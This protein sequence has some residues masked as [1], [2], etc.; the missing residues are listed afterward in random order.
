MFVP[1][2]SSTG[3]PMMPTCPARA[4]R[5]LKAK[6]A[7]SFWSRGVFCIR[8]ND[9][10]ESSTQTIAVGV[11]PGSKREGYTVK[12]KNH[13]F[14]NV[15]SDARTGVKESIETR[16]NARRA[17]R[18][19]KTPCRANLRNKKRGQLPPSTKARW[20]L[21]L[22]VCKWLCRLYPVKAFVVEDV[23][24]K[25]IKGKGSS[26]NAGFSPII[27]GKKWF[28]EQLEIL[29]RVELKRGYQTFALRN[30]HGLKKSSNKLSKQFDAHCVD[31]WV[32]ANLYTGGHTKPD[33][34]AM[35]FISPIQLHR[36]QLHRFQPSTDGVRRRYGGTRSIG[37][38]RGSLVRHIKHGLTYV[39]GTANG[40]LSL[41]DI[42]SG[43]RL[44]ANAKL[45][46]TTFVCFNPWKFRN[47][48]MSGEVSIQKGK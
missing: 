36:R 22:N 45:E 2:L 48:A 32:L 6:R 14:I 43:K 11:D 17:R 46:H 27:I 12:S 25:T 29:G 1:V 40:R 5:L 23:N 41:H 47:V 26:W 20:Q 34:E 30:Q 37:F 8:M 44:C 4:K 38:K 33:N 18:Q 24:A 28:Y 13:T 42:G 10:A 31:S 16:R 39:G 19:R 9:I 35:I 21:K 7:H 15:L 3:Q